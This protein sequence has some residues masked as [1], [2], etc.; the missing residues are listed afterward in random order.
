MQKFF[1]I[2][3]TL[4]FFSSGCL[5]SDDN[6]DLNEEDVLDLQDKDISDLENDNLCN[7]TEIVEENI[8]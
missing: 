8:P 6:S 3:L 7:L 5:T 2:V 1:A 4:M